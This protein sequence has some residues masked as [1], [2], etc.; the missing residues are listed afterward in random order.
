MRTINDFRVTAQT[1]VGIYILLLV[2]VVL[3]EL[4]VRLHPVLLATILGDHVVSTS[5]DRSH[6]E[7][8]KESEC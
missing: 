6:F 5:R 7:K 1:V 2:H 3:P 4:G 8:L